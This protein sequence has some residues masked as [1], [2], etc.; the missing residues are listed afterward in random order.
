[1]GSLLGKVNFEAQPIATFNHI[2][3]LD[4]F[5]AIWDREIPL[6]I[7]SEKDKDGNS[8]LFTELVGGDILTVLQNMDITLPT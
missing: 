1:M 5:Q 4:A 6:Y 8:V 2:F 3:N 7:R